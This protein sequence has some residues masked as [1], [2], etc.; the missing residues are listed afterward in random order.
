MPIGRATTTSRPR[1]ASELARELLGVELGAL[2]DVAGIERRVLVGRRMLDVTVHAAGAAVDDAPDAGGARRLEHMARAVDVDRAIRASRAA[3]LRDRSRR[4]DRR[5]S[6][7]VDGALRRA[8]A[9][10]RS[11]STA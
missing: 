10:A 11:P 3:R 1:V 7:A 8:A 2:I 9:S 5:R 4:C 6:H